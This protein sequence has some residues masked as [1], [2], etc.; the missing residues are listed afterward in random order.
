MTNPDANPYSSWFGAGGIFLKAGDDAT[1]AAADAEDIDLDDL[2]I[3][4][5]LLRE[6]VLAL[7]LAGY[8]TNYIYL[9]TA[10]LAATHP[11]LQISLDT[12]EVVIVDGIGELSVNPASSGQMWQ[13]VF[14]LQPVYFNGDDV[15]VK[16]DDNFSATLLGLNSDLVAS[17]LPGMDISGTGGL[18]L[19]GI[20]ESTM[21]DALLGFAEPFKA[22]VVDYIVQQNK[23]L[24]FGYVGG[25][26]LTPLYT[27]DAWANAVEALEDE[28]EREVFLKL[29]GDIQNNIEN[30][31]GFGGFATIQIASGKDSRPE[32]CFADETLLDSLRANA[33]GAHLARAIGS[34]ETGA[35]EPARTDWYRGECLTSGLIEAAAQ[36]DPEMITYGSPGESL[37]DDEE[38]YPIEVT[39][40]TGG[41]RGV[42][43]SPYGETEGLNID[44]VNDVFGL[45][46]GSE[47]DGFEKNSVL[48]QYFSWEF[49]DPS[50]WV[51]TEDENTPPPTLL[52]VAAPGVQISGRVRL[53]DEGI[54]VLIH[55]VQDYNTVPP[56][57]TRIQSELYEAPVALGSY[58]M[59]NGESGS[60]PAWTFRPIRA[61]DAKRTGNAGYILRHPAAKN[62]DSQYIEIIIEFP[63]ES[64]SC[65]VT[66]DFSPQP[67]NEAIAITGDDGSDIKIKRW[68]VTI[69][70]SGD[71]DISITRH[72]TAA[73]TYAFVTNVYKGQANS[74][75]TVPEFGRRINRAAYAGIGNESYWE[76][77]ISIEYSSATA[78]FSRLFWDYGTIVVDVGV[79]FIPYVGD[80]VD[81]IEFVNAVVTGNDKWGRPVTNFDMALM[82]GGM[83]LPFVGAGALKGAKN[84][85]TRSDDIIDVS[86]DLLKATDLPSTVVADV[87]SASAGILSQADAGMIAA[88]AKSGEH[89]DEALVIVTEYGEEL[90]DIARRQSGAIAADDVMAPGGRGFTLPELQFAR[91]QALDAAERTVESLDEFA[92]SRAA[93]DVDGVA[94]DL[95]GILDDVEDLDNL[96]E[97]ALKVDN[98]VKGDNSGFLD[99]HA[100]L[101]SGFRKYKGGGGAKNAREWALSQTTGSFR[102]IL[103]RMFGDNYAR[104]S[105][106]VRSTQR[107][108]LFPSRQ[109]IL[110]LFPA[111]ARTSALTEGLTLALKEKDAIGR[112]VGNLHPDLGPTEIAIIERVLAKASGVDDIADL[113]VDGILKLT[114]ESRHFPAES[115]LDGLAHGVK[116]MKR[117]IDDVS[118]VN[119]DDVLSVN[120]IE[121]YF[122]DV[123]TTST[124]EHAS[125]FEIYGL[126]KLLG[127]SGVQPAD[128]LFQLALVG[129]KGPDIIHFV[130]GEAKVIQYKSFKNLSGLLTTTDS[131]A[132]YKQFVT[133]IKRLADNDFLVDALDGG[134]KVPVNRT[135]E[136]KIDWTRVK[137]AAEATFGAMEDQLELALQVEDYYV[138]AIKQEAALQGITEEFDVIIDFM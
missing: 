77:F 68:D 17:L 109:R 12:D 131:S 10:S 27:A 20:D 63:E 113:T 106:A 125:E 136:F 135:I 120:N 49:F 9:Q 4:I 104:A 79:G 124:Y 56:W 29:L 117:A 52:V 138:Q 22:A 50:I 6:P 89:M 105:S 28:N 99:G 82:A 119:I 14:S 137:G 48:E 54:Q 73:A 57:G 51:I 62:G 67:L 13:I 1:L 128:V 114:G 130:A 40:K 134:G 78:E 101:E 37:L 129:R 74:I 108:A 123:I 53:E 126:C 46:T 72:A 7:L 43:I 96:D 33:K 23:A 111:A 107:G 75:E 132:I 69:I 97:I 61:E 8:K 25:A 118:G 88:A 44:V 38:T 102:Q 91:Q 100:D 94:D 31:T 11:W 30:Y 64:P 122:K 86:V 87:A 42:V 18:S 66:F 36:C 35:E 5:F 92:L 55:R 133:D 58:A 103:V 41:A 95:A 3:T 24:G 85:L 127:E 26:G 93:S 32:E 81:V 115:L 84:L 76:L 59:V 45:F 60:T 47:Q 19:I 16:F 65:R 34:F 80:A 121:D 90:G 70:S 112:I 98:I 39:H 71:V 15:N 2:S 116:K 21:Q 110:L 83:L